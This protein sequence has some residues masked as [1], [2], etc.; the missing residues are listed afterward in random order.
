MTLKLS[1]LPVYSEVHP[2]SKHQIGSVRLLKHQV[3]TLAA[4]NDPD[5][6]VIFNVAMTGDGKSLAAYLPAFQQQKN[7]IAMYPTNELV[8]DQYYALPRYEQ[9]L[10]IRLPRYG[11]MYSD[12]ITQLMR[13]NDNKVR[14]EEVRKLLER[15]GI[16]LTNPDLIHLMMSHQYGWDHQRKELPVT[17]GAYFDYFLFDEFHIFGVPQVI[18]VMNMLGY[19][20]VNY[21]N[22]PADRKK[23][24]FL[25]ATP[26]KLMN[27]LLERG[28]LRYKKIEGK[29]LST[30]QQGYSCILQPCELE[31]HEV[32]QEA[33]TEMWV[34]E[35]L[36]DIL[37]FFKQHPQ[38]KAAILV[39]SVATAR[40]LYACLKEYFKPH[41][42]TVGENTG[43]THPDERRA[44]F[45]KHILVGTSTVD[46]GVDF[47]IN[48]LIFEA[49]NAGSFLQ[50]FGRLGRHA[51]YPIYHAHALLPRFVLER[52]TLKLDTRGEVERETFNKAIREAF[53]VEAEFK[54][55]TQLWGVVQAA[56]V[57][58]ELQGQSKKDANE[59]FTSALSSQYDL[60]YGAQTQPVMS[61][62]LK[63][64][65]AIRNKQPEILA[66]LSS[67]R[68]LSP[69]S[70]GVWDTDNHL[71]TYDLFFLLANT[72]FEVLSAAEFMQEVM[73]QGLEERD[74]KDQLLYLKIIKYVPERQQLV[75]GLPF[76]V[77]DYAARL[78]TVQ[79]LDNFFV[80][81][82]SFT[83][84]DQVNRV[85]K[86]KSLT[87]ILSDMGR[88][89]LK[90][91]LNLPTMFPIQRL[92]DKTGAEYAVAF[93][94]EALLLDSLLSWRKTKGDQA[95]F[96]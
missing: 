68:G 25:S 75:L 33:P 6:D 18:S 47:R 32:S 21:H 13:E 22:K 23:F 52:L 96:L 40:R 12:K 43:L 53:P 34:L 54:S 62:A 65:W 76:V 28:G 66:E 93:G 87:C 86:T 15:N 85:L 73:R 42:I 50:R 90:Q 44:S 20:N 64:Y 51:G 89:E 82:P 78:H 88:K 24:I 19:L 3:E 4:F 29:Y 57:L 38:S 5:I 72:E 84:R 70:C 74:Y 95:M 67:F 26:S 80:R 77:A 61:K 79:V 55:H 8:Q 14:L 56:Q 27:D 45:E 48:Y 71:Q 39:Y 1:I 35:H 17:I 10:Q 2:D 11:T 31:L 92:Q 30:E 69:L 49:Y 58:A 9:N 83:G 94:Q 60:F 91:R 37:S 81:E 16:L 63:K 59:A 7:I 36:Q 41:N 46:I